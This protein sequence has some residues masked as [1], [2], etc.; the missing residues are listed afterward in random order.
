MKLNKEH[1]SGL[2]NLKLR[3][4]DSSIFLN[5]SVSNKYSM[6]MALGSVCDIHIAFTQVHVTYAKLSQHPQTI[7]TWIGP[8]IGERSHVK[9]DFRIY[10]LL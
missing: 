5:I 6:R 9:Y 4:I 3:Y 1:I 8:I 2:I 10:W 7:L